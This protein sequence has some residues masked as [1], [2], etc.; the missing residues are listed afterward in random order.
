MR[1]LLQPYLVQTY[2]SVLADYKHNFAIMDKFPSSCVASDWE[3]LFKF[4]WMYGLT[5]Y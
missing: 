2:S 1:N 5:I 3:K 4:R